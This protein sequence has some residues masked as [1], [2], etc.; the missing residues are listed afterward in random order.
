MKSSLVSK[1]QGQ[2]TIEYLFI[3]IFIV[4]LSLKVVGAF[5]DFMRESV[6]N[7]GHE[8]SVNL[9]SGVCETICYFPGYRNSNSGTE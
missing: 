8:L 1:S 4:G 9:S 7:L 2:A 3:L 5:S 6:G